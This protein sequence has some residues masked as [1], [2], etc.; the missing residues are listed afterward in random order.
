MRDKPKGDEVPVPSQLPAAAAVADDEMGQE[1]EV[2]EPI[3]RE[4]AMLAWSQ[5]WR[6][7]NIPPAEEGGRTKKPAKEK[8]KHQPQA[9]Y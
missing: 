3:T 1:E 2:K 5:P 9:P 4:A 8:K 6:P 7:P